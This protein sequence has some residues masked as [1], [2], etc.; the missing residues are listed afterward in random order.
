MAG[1]LIIPLLISGF[2]VITKHPHHFYRLHRYDGQLLYIKAS[3][4]GFYCFSIAVILAL[5]MKWLTA[6]FHPVMFVASWAEFSNNP[7]ENRW[8]GW[9]L[10]V[11]LCSVIIGWLWGMLAR[12]GYMIRFARAVLA[13]QYQCETRELYHYL[14]LSVLASLMAE[15]PTN[16]LFFESMMSKRTI[17][18]TLKCSK[19]YVGVITRLSEPNESDGPIQEISLLP[20]MSG[21]REQESRRINFINNYINLGDTDTH[22]TIPRDEVTH[23]S[24]FTQELHHRIDRNVLRQ[25]TAAND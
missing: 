10:V 17:L 20:L 24:W 6:S 15:T 21:F 23:A 11:S 9:M 16:K 1:L 12:L 8:Y 14:R 25:T 4:Y 18:L 19:V 13:G 3:V 5:L 22:I 2:L 7:A